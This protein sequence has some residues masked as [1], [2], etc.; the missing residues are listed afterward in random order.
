MPSATTDSHEI[1]SMNPKTSNTSAPARFQRLV[2]DIQATL[3]SNSS[4]ISSDEIRYA[5][6]ELLQQYRS[7]DEGWEEFAFQDSAL[8]FT[9]NLADAGNGEYNL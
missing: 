5:L 9:R 1:T 3:G 4:I 8:P 2:Q 7:E 6:E